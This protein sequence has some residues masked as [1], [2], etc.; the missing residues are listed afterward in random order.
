MVTLLMMTEAMRD[1]DT[2]PPHNVTSREPQLRSNASRIFLCSNMMLS[3]VTAPFRRAIALG[4]LPRLPFSTLANISVTV[5]KRRTPI[6]ERESGP[7]KSWQWHALRPHRMQVEGCVLSRSFELNVLFS[8]GSFESVTDGTISAPARMQHGIPITVAA[9]PGER[10]AP[11]DPKRPRDGPGDV[12]GEFAVLARENARGSVWPGRA[13][14][15]GG[16][17]KI[18]DG[19]SQIDYMPMSVRE[20][21][22]STSAE[23]RTSNARASPSE[24]RRT[25]LVR[26]RRTGRAGRSV[27]ASVWRRRGGSS[28]EE[29][30]ESEAEEEEK[31]KME[32]L[33][34]GEERGDDASRT[35]R[36]KRGKREKQITQRRFENRVILGL[37]DM[38]GLRARTYGTSGNGLSS[39]REVSESVI[40]VEG[41]TA[42]GGASQFTIM[43][44]RALRSV[45]FRAQRKASPYTAE[46]AWDLRYDISAG[47]EMIV[48][49]GLRWCH[50]WRTNAVI[51]VIDP[52]PRKRWRASTSLD[53]ALGKRHTG[54]GD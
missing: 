47:M 51:I 8:G 50:V 4:Q 19:G 11:W 3:H 9:A 18:L 24:K 46:K 26:P 48:V 44:S 12:T 32:E 53:S 31:K 21:E 23:V 40:K 10:S 38:K 25:V 5:E 29:A 49:A 45:V 36:G 27:E 34:E 54:T 41:Q 13:R 16:D 20:R 15:V 28:S 35:E 39:T 6:P 14:R 33:E 2:S 37:F 1:L 30:E 43:A 52:L 42:N 22:A 17:P 7:G